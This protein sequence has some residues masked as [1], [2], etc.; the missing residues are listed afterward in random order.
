MNADKLKELIWVVGG[1]IFILRDV[2]LLAQ[3]GNK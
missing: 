1:K 2:L 3:R